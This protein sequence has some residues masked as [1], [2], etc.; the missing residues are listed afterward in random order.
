MQLYRI[1]SE[2]S[3][4]INDY[5][6]VDPAVFPGPSESFEL[7]I[8][9]GAIPRGVFSNSAAAA[10]D[11]KSIATYVWKSGFVVPLL[12]CVKPEDVGPGS[13]RRRQ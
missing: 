3:G 4:I 9:V 12:S 8:A 6:M 7:C 13:F 5:D 2:P 1:T 11:V 10:S